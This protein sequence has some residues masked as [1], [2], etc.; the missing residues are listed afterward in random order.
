[1]RRGVIFDKCICG[2]GRVGVSD[3]KLRTAVSMHIQVTWW[4]RRR[5]P[6]FVPHARLSS[7]CVSFCA[8]GSDMVEV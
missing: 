1:V 8:G 6:V 4:R 2:C 5:L 3:K 7:V